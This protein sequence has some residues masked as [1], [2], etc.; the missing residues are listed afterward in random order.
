MF[1]RVRA[2]NA[3]FSLRMRTSNL[4]LQHL[5]AIAHANRAVRSAAG[6]FDII[7]FKG[8]NIQHNI[9]HRNFEFIDFIFSGLLCGGAVAHRISRL[10]V[11]FHGQPEA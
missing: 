6:C 9:F 7:P 1:V 3:I 8:K 2:L 11:F 5:H 4:R 10:I